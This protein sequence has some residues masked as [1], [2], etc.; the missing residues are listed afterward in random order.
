MSFNFEAIITKHIQT[1]ENGAFSCHNKSS[2][3]RGFLYIL[4]SLQALKLVSCHNIF[5]EE[6]DTLF[7]KRYEI[8]FFIPD[9]DYNA[10]HVPWC[11]TLNNNRDENLW[12]WFNE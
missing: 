3:Q 10:R 8:Q 5:A 7:E 11:S 4:F 2:K 12:H 1:R 9:G 6:W